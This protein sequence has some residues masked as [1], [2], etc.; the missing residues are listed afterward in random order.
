[1]RFQPGSSGNPGGRKPGIPSQTAKLRAALEKEIPEIL[2][3]LVERAK[4]GDGP[5]AKLIL[6]RCLPALKP[7]TRPLPPKTPEDPREVVGAVA[8]GRLTLEQG[9]ELLGMAAQAA[10]V[11]G[12]VEMESR[13]AAL[14]ALLAQPHD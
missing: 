8:S 6:E 1:M 13:L 10:A 14:E 4:N 3:A 11:E 5:S 2:S 9:R 12:L 7:E